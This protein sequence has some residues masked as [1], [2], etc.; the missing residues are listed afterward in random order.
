MKENLNEKRN[1]IWQINKGFGDKNRLFYDIRNISVEGIK[2]V[3]NDNNIYFFLN[4]DKTTPTLL[5]YKYNC[6]FSMMKQIYTNIEFIS[7][8][9]KKLNSCKPVTVMFICRQFL[10]LYICS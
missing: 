2:P 7:W 8:M 5:L 4:N 6:K 9:T 3:L 1:D 10:S